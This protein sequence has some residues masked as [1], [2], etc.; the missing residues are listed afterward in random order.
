VPYDEPLSDAR[1]PLADFFRILLNSGAT[2]RLPRPASSQA[3]GSYSIGDANRLSVRDTG[4]PG[5]LNRTSQDLLLVLSVPWGDLHR[6]LF[7]DFVL[8][9]CKKTMVIREN[10]DGVYVWQHSKTFPQPFSKVAASEA[11]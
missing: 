6:L 1:T 3:M 8:T 10:S 9:G 7:I 5:N 11:G 4:P 2:A